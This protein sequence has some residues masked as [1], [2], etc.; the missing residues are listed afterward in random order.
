MFYIIS[1]IIFT[2]PGNVI[3]SNIIGIV[4]LGFYILY[5]IIQNNYNLKINKVIISYFLFLCFMALSVFWSEDTNLSL[6]NLVITLKAFVIS[7]IIY[8]I[9]TK[10]HIIEYIYYG[11]FI[12]VLINILVYFNLIQVNYEVSHWFRFHG[13]TGN[14]NVLALIS[15]FSILFSILLLHLKNNLSLII[16]S[17]LYINILASIYLIILS[18]SKKGFILGV[19][20][21]FA[22]SITLI[23]N[24]KNF[25]KI[26]MYLLFLIFFLIYF[27]DVNV[28]LEQIEYM[29]QRMGDFI[30]AINGK[31]MDTTNSQRMQ[32]VTEGSLLA[33]NYPL[34]GHGINTFRKFFGLYAH[35]N[36]IEL[37]FG[38]GIVGLFI[39]YSMY[40]FLIKEIF[41]VNDNIL[42]RYLLLIVFV[43]LALD[44]AVV[45]YYTKLSLIILFSLPNIISENSSNTKLQGNSE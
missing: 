32:F 31:S 21:I 23:K 44:L 1:L 26:S 3:Y 45:S 17:Y 35:N 38:L 22:Y 27:I 39:Y 34:F 14:P 25:L 18:A 30:N 16:K 13:T 12:G 43:Y 15:L 6:S 7:F 24:K 33:E 29:M 9:V 10:H 4:Y 19:I 2:I 5:S 37:F 40:Y 8:N 41:K 36:Y 42:K 11:I 20:I 28:F